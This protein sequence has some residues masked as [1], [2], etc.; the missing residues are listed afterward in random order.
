VVAATVVMFWSGNQ[1][2]EARYE[3]QRA[4][5]ARAEAAADRD[6]AR[7][8]ADLAE[9]RAIDA[10]AAKTQAERDRVT[11]RQRRALAEAAR[12]AAE[13][14]RDVAFVSG[15]IWGLTRAP[16]TDGSLPPSSPGGGPF[17]ANA[18]A[19]I[20]P[21]E[22]ETLVEDERELRAE[23]EERLRNLE[24]ATEKASAETRAMRDRAARAE[25]RAAEAQT[26]LRA[27]RRAA[28]AMADD[29]RRER[30][31]ANELS[32]EVAELTREVGAVRNPTH[33]AVAESRAAAVAALDDFL[34]AGLLRQA[35][36]RAPYGRSVRAALDDAARR[37]DGAFPRDPLVEAVV[38]LRLARSYL[39]ISLPDLARPLAARAVTVRREVLGVEHWDVGEAMEVLVDAEVRAGVLASAERTARDLLNVRRRTLGVHDEVAVSLER[40]A[41]VQRA[42]GET[43]RAARLLE[44]AL[45]LRR[46]LKGNEH[47]ATLDVIERLA[48]IRS[49]QRRFDDAEMN[50]V[51]ALDIRRRIHAE[52]DERIRATMAMLARFL[53][54]RGRSEE[55]ADLYAELAAAWKR[56]LPSRHWRIAEARSGY[57]AALTR[58]DRFDEAEAAL[59]EAFD[60]LMEDKRGPESAR[61]LTVERLAELY[62]RKGDAER[63]RRWRTLLP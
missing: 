2:R 24:Q 50:Y 59:L 36:A 27:E 34:V 40:L 57:G 53:L 1:V 5:T 9:K 21:G 47:S 10:E 3:T 33:R 18:G 60:D 61:R 42:Q 19:A 43:D 7:A 11:E 22:L 29:V 63:A 16:G 46:Q 30:T 13:S 23:A 26:D 48:A 32:R 20:I 14:M 44:E 12:G 35:T 54:E 55:A 31:R 38:A 45:L 52:D 4:R 8:A 15:T 28:E 51:M 49:E 6:R 37:L 41:E 17:R 56:L 62:A 39:A 58:R 25:R